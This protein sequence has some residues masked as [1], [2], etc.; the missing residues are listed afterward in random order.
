V[1]IFSQLASVIKGGV[2]EVA[3]EDLTPEEAE[4]AAKKARIAFHRDSVRNGPVKFRYMTNGQ[5]RRAEERARKR[6]AKKAFRGE[7]RSHFEKLR[8]A[9]GLR[10]HLQ[11]VGLIPFVDGHEATLEDQVTSTAWIQQRYGVEVTNDGVG[12][13]H[14]SFRRGDILDGLKNAARFYESATGLIVRVPA[15]FEPAIYVDEAAE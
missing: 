4:A 15:D 10:G 12:T 2:T 14:V 1:N 11:A 7:V 5:V 13:G 9:A 3:D 6:N 8:I